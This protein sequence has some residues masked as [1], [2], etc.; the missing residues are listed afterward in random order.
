MSNEFYSSGYYGSVNTE[1]KV[2]QHNV[3]RN[4]V[5]AWSDWTDLFVHFLDLERNH[6]LISKYLGGPSY[7]YAMSQGLCGEYAYIGVMVP[8][9]DNDGKP[10]PF[11]VC[12]ML[13]GDCNPITENQ[14]LNAWYAAAEKIIQSTKKSGFQSLEL[15]ASLLELDQIFETMAAPATNRHI[16]SGSGQ[17]AIRR[18]LTATAPTLSNYQDMLHVVLS[19]IC[20]GY[21]IWQTAGNDSVEAS[22]LLTQGLP[23]IESVVAMFDGQWTKHGWVNDATERRT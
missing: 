8:N 23:P 4:F 9:V 18:P 3:N 16:S 19:E 15:A 22:M 6:N 10:A 21:S 11:T 14:R 5:N 1:P 13:P 7:R 20:F 2:I 12:A 17:V